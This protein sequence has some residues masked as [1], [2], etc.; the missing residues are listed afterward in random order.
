LKETRKRS[1]LGEKMIRE[2]YQGPEA[3]RE[4]LSSQLESVRSI[5]RAVMARR[6]QRILLMG[7]GTSYHAGVV[8]AYALNRLTDMLSIPVQASEFSQFAGNSIRPG[9]IL[10]AYS[11]SGEST[12]TIEALKSA[13]AKGAYAISITNTPGSTMTRESDQ[14][15][16]TQ[17]G[18]EESVVAT[19]TFEAQLAV[20][21]A[22]AC[23]IAESGGY[24]T[25]QRSGAIL[26][27]LSRAPELIRGELDGW[28]KLTAKVAAKL[29]KM[30]DV[31]TLGSGIEYGVALE[32]GLKLKEASLTH[33]E[34]F[35]VAEFRH[36]PQSLVTSGVAVIMIA[37]EPGKGM[38]FSDKLARE[39]KEKKATLVTIV[40]EGRPLAKGVSDLEVKVPASD[41]IVSPI[42][43]TV[44]IQLLSYNLA[45]VRNIN[46]DSPRHLTKVVKLG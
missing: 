24:I 20:T 37:P 44:P 19:K 45:I 3:I 13:R 15:I 32:A 40:D 36:G 28:R 38:E 5:A 42:L 14:S 30:H 22:L 1:V 6:P 39:L 4:T 25:S 21:I 16:V 12:D 31:F 29:K 11:Q 41:P 34:A 23:L 8:G 9:D 17:A 18:P 10:I 43:Q 26:Q 46:P 7:S 27:S 33:S 35:S 2:I